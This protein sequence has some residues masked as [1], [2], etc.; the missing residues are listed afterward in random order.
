MSKGLSRV[1]RRV[2]VQGIKQ[3]A[4]KT[5]HKARGIALQTLYSLDINGRIRNTSFPYTE[6]FA[7]QSEE[8]EA[9]LESEVTLYALYLINGTLEHLKALDEVIGKY[10]K[11]RSLENISYVDR[12]ILRLSI[13][14][15]FF[16]KDVDANVVIDEGVKLSLEYSTEI[17]YRF[18]NGVLDSVVRDFKAGK[19]ELY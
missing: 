14:T 6:G 17:N 5:R 13:F 2:S 10:S 16:C 1:F 12:N 18:I 8:E 7:G 3:V 4:M 9:S 15:L 19:L 11:K